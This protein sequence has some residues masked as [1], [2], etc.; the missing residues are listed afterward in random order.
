MNL[1]CQY[2]Y[3]HTYT[4]IY[5]VYSDHLLA[6][7][8]IVLGVNLFVVER[9]EWEEEF[10]RGIFYCFKILRSA[11]ALCGLNPREGMELMGF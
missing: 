5:K 11:S 2:I 6:L 10:E 4:D 1:R 3:V 7:G 9:V 8:V